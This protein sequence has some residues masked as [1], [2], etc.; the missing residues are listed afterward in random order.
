MVAKYSSQMDHI[1]PARV[2]DL[3]AEI[4]DFVNP[5]LRVSWSSAG[6]DQFSGTGE[7]IFS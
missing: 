3:R 7:Y 5:T 4:L 2:T 6:D 1:A